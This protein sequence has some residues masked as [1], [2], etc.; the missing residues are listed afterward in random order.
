MLASCM[1]HSDLL[2]DY[3]QLINDDVFTSFKYV[4]DREHKT[5][6]LSMSA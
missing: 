6:L 3:L 4:A 2:E 1:R 5:I